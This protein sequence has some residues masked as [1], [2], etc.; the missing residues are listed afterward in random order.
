[1]EA[2]YVNIM[3]ASWEPQGVGTNIPILLKTTP[4]EDKGWA[5]AVAQVVECPS[6]KSEAEFKPQYCIKKR[7]CQ[8][9]G[10]GGSSI[11]LATWE[12]WSLF[13]ASLDK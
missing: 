8:G 11:I 10:T 13:K 1:M 5:V 9:L 4:K 3:F 12:D 6:S 2:H 7:K